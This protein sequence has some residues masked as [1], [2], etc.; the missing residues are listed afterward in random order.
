[1]SIRN[2]K[3]E[4]KKRRNRESTGEKGREYRGERESVQGRREFFFFIKNRGVIEEITEGNR[5]RR[6]EKQ[7]RLCNR[8]EEEKQ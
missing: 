2:E 5:G 8:E 3:A 4:K 1:V 7:W 6:E